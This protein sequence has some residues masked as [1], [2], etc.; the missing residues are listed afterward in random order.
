MRRQWENDEGFIPCNKAQ[1][2]MS[3]RVENVLGLENNNIPIGIPSCPKSQK[4]E[5][6]MSSMDH[7][8]KEF[9]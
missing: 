1:S 6:F 5:V 8:N 9:K 7:A 2:V 4:R 3:F